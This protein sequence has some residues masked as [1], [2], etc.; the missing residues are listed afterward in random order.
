M[1]KEP[2]Q[3]SSPA[4]AMWAVSPCSWLPPMAKVRA[5]SSPRP[6]RS[7]RRGAM[8]AG[9]STRGDG[10]RRSSWVVKPVGRSASR[11]SRKCAGPRPS[12]SGWAAKGVAGSAEQAP[13]TSCLTGSRVRPEM[14]PGGPWILASDQSAGPVPRVTV[15]EWDWPEE[16]SQLILTCCPGLELAMAVDSADGPAMVVPFTAVIVSP[17]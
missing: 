11:S 10:W 7:C 16:S 2:L 8:G 5:R 12:E 3:S 15:A 13:P 9:R 4:I 17:A 14:T 6:S 1:A